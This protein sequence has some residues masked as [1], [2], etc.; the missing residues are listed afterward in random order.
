MA[1][2]V[3]ADALGEEWKG[4]VVQISDGNNKQGFAMMQGVWTHGH[5]CLLLSKRHSFLL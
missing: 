3:A 5:V 4:Y 2:E 1:T